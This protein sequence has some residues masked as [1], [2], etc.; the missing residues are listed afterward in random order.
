V[1]C[2]K[3]IHLSVKK[4]YKKIKNAIMELKLTHYAVSYKIQPEPEHNISY[5]CTFL[6]ALQELSIFL[7]GID[8]VTSELLFKI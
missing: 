6:R 2:R 1:S 5:H 8:I 3:I 7:K 4:V